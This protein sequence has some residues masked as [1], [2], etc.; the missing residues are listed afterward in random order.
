MTRRVVMYSTSWCPDCRRAE[1]V[2]S[3][4]NIAFEKVDI[5][6]VEGA[7]EIVM[8]HAGGKRVVPTLV[9]EENGSETVLVNPRPLE[10]LSALGVG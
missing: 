9:V 2:L 5:E 10:L 3:E 7:A 1:R 8:T 6:H 4:Q